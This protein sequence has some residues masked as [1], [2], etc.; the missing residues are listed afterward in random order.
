VV[1]DVPAL[2]VPDLVAA[3][4]AA[5]RRGREGRLTARDLASGAVGAVS[6]LGARG[7]DS[8]TGIVPAGRRL[9]LTTGRIAGRPAAVDGRLAVRTTL[10]A[11]LNVDHRYLDGDRAADVLDAFDREFRALHT[12][13]GEGDQ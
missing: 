13:A 5:V 9:L 12:W 8:F 11:T 4:Q 2:A 7:V 3:R 1:P 6:N 10:I